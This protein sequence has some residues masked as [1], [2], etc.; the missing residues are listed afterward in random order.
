MS[1]FTIKDH[2]HENQLFLG[3]AVVTGVVA[4]LLV[5]LLVVRLVELQIS[6]HDHYKTLS[7]E[8]RVKLVPLP[9]T[10]G[11]IHDRNGVLL[12]QNVPFYSLEV[13]P[14]RAD[15]MQ[16]TLAELGKI[17]Q[18]TPADRERFDR[19]RRRRRRFEG[20]PIRLR[21]NEEEVARFGV[22]RHR[23]PAVDIQARLH[24]EY[25][26]GELTS[27][28]LGYVGRISEQ[29]L[30]EIDGSAYAGTDYI[31]K[32]GVEKTYEQ[33]LHGQVGLQ[34]VEINAPGRILRVLERTPPVPGADLRLY[35][36]VGLQKEAV[37]ALGDA[38]GAVVAIEPDT[39]GVLALV[40]KP[41]FDPNLFVEGIDNTSFQALNLSEDKPLFNRA[42][43]GQYPPGSTIKPFVGLTG[44]ELGVTTAGNTRYC[45]GFLQLPGNTHKYRDWKR[46]G[47]GTVDLDRAIVES[48]DVYFYD[49]ARN[50]GVNRLHDF[51]AQFGF[52]TR[53]G[54]DL[55]GERGGLLPS[56]DWKR[57]TYRQ[58]WY[59]GETL[60]LGIGQGYLLTTPLQLAHAT[61]VLASHGRSLVP[62][63]VELVQ[64][65]G[66]GAEPPEGPPEQDI[67]QVNPANWDRVIESM[68]RVVNS[69]HGTARSIRS[70]A[71]M[72]AG[73]T[74]TAQVFTVK[75]D[76]K[77]DADNVDEKLRDHALFIAF[78]PA[79]AP[80]IAVAAIV[81]H[82]GHGGS[83][84]APIAAR[85]I[86]RYLGG[87]AQ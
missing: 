12:A 25:P 81:E 49:L 57:A 35:I 82:G 40:S 72:I 70:D 80:R 55:F 39:G 23:F 65:P 10:R 4:V 45:P 52:G 20:I 44:L 15:D 71:Y 66:S 51:L 41:G 26:L 31:G 73:K 8:N 36:D 53:T 78:A 34:Q 42:I 83:V 32:I 13:V 75:Q 77:Y 16:Q 14:E 30:Q 85:V 9:P 27:H 58:P 24:R 59:P 60:I 2:L 21:L 74:G 5:G 19:L 6:S 62:R 18:I 61:S 64:P 56:S 37:E 68:R 47:H 69:E 76:E 48:C 84:A 50:I 22:N 29:E 17:I 3:R 38:N 11:L 43:R 79:E 7:R 86:A 54:I 63:V 87:S 1:R 67:P 33:I 28:V 46:G